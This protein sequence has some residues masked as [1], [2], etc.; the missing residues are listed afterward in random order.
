MVRIKRYI[1]LY[2]HKSRNVFSVIII[3]AIIVLCLSL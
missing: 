3:I 2:M 1:L